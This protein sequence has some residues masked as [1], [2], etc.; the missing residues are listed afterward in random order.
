MIS[1]RK[2]DS[3]KKESKKFGDATTGIVIIIVFLL[4]FAIGNV[5]ITM[6][7]F[8]LIQNPYT[9]PLHITPCVTGS[10]YLIRYPFYG[11]LL[12]WDLSLTPAW[13]S[14]VEAMIFP[15]M[16]TILHSLSPWLLL[17]LIFYPFL[18][19]LLVMVSVGL[20]R[21]K[22]WARIFTIIFF[23]YSS[24]FAVLNLKCVG[25][26]YI[27]FNINTL[28]VFA[29]IGTLGE[30]LILVIA[31]ILHLILAIGI[32]GYLF[33]DV[34]YRFGVKAEIKKT[35]KTE[36]DQIL[37]KRDAHVSGFGRMI[38]EAWEKEKEYRRSK[39]S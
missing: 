30:G 15:I 37:S 20:V 16:Y 10:C 38:R 19:L 18:S 3:R 12:F 33:G 8:T 26:E 6:F 5:L 17:Q 25:L 28:S 23:A 36:R 35:I 11:I 1:S 13:N 24:I 21:M 22:N 39:N 14:F 7:F 31:N 4:L 2:K 27:L 9:L 32:V 29:I 34:R